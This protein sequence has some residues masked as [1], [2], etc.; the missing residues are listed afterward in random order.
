MQLMQTKWRT[1][2][3]A[4]SCW[5]NLTWPQD[6][7]CSR[8]HFACKNSNI[9]VVSG[10]A[11]YPMWPLSE[12]YCRTMPLLPWP[13]WFEIQEVKGDAASWVD[14][15]KDCFDW[16]PSNF[17]EGPTCKCTVLCGPFIRKCIWKEGGEGGW[18]CGS[19]RTT[20]LD[21]C[22]CRKSFNELTV[23]SESFGW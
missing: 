21:W 8:Y 23:P 15:F 20:R 19:R 2:Q 1:S 18:C 7:H 5:L 17:C 6:K 10:G 14:F 4:L 16:G 22:I 9:P 3:Y 11:T 13:S 12:D